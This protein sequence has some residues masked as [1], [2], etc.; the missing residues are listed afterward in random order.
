M[1][2]QDFLIRSAIGVLTPLLP[3]SPQNKDSVSAAPKP[4]IQELAPRP[5]LGW[6]SFNSYGVYFHEKAAYDN[7]NAFAK[8]LKPHGYEYFVVDGGWAGEYKLVPGTMYPAEK[9]ASTLNMDQYGLL[10]PSKTYFPNG[11]KP[12]ADKAHALG[13]KFGIHLMR[14]IP[15]KAVELN[16]P[17]KGTRYRLADIAD[18]T[19]IC[20]WYP[21]TYGVDVTKPGAQ[22]YYNAVFKKLAGWGVDFIKVDDLIPFPDEILM[23]ANAI[24][25]SARPMVYSLSPGSTANLRHLP[26]YR[27]ANMVR[28]TYDI[29]DRT[30]DFKTAFDR[31]RM[32]QGLG[33]PGFWPDLDM[34]PFGKL[35]LMQPAELDNKK[36]EVK[37][38]G[39]GN[40]RTSYLTN[41]EMQTFITIR[42]LAA[43]PLMMGGDL[44]T[45]DDYSLRLI[46]HPDMLACNQNG[47]TG[48]LVCEKDNVEVWL[49]NKAN[50]FGSGWFGVFN[51]SGAAKTVVLSA[52]EL[53]LNFLPNVG[54]D[55]TRYTIRDIWADRPIAANGSSFSF[56]VAPNGVSFC[57]Y[58]AQRSR[59]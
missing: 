27:R 45:L 46:T 15:R 57:S 58:A 30:E 33:T 5:P 40:T 8:Q 48:T 26:Y 1:N 34:I 25:Q 55:H 37:L 51:R 59:A 31:W 35:Q 7:L 50:D 23:I 36:R 11:L 6:N 42:A 10:E 24:E 19:S 21:N 22:E 29:W 47:Q 28:V 18:K 56:T 12:I 49:T 3:T 43:S 44:P 39:F 32:F 52:K 14:G 38:S 54:A 16:L 53:G 4:S 20:N 9:H 17:I 2:R 13:I 41:D